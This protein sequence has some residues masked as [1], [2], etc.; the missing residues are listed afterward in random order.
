MD[1]EEGIRDEGKPNRYGLH[2]CRR[3]ANLVRYDPDLC[4]ACPFEGSEDRA[5]PLAQKRVI[6]S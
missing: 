3:Y 4:S 6:K 2:F 5:I 1:A